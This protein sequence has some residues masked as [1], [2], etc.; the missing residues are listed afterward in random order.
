M[1]SF[2]RPLRLPEPAPIRPLQ[3]CSAS[4]S[5]ATPPPTPPPSDRI[6]VILLGPHMVQ[7]DPHLKVLN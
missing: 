1:P 4:T 7:D 6:P 3:Q 2:P 5:A